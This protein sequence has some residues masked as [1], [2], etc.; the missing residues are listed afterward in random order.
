[1]KSA[2]RGYWICQAVGWGAYL[3]LTV[4]QV[5]ADAGPRIGPQAE[6]V[7]AAAFGVALTHAFRRLV[8]ARGW[9]SLELRAL[10]PRAVLSPFVL[11]VVFVLPLVAIE[12]LLLG[13][14]SGVVVFVAAVVRW[15]LVFAVWEGIYLGVVLFRARRRAERERM[16]L[17][18][19][20][21][22]AQLDALRSQLNPHFLFNALNTVRALIPD[23]PARAQTAVTQLASILRHALGSSRADLVALESELAIADDYLAIESLRLGERLKVERTIDPAALRARVP[24]MLVQTLVENAIK[25][26]IAELR[27]GGTLS[28]CAEVHDGAMLLRVENPRPDGEPR[29]RSGDNGIGLA[30]ARE[31]M[32][33]LFGDEGRVEIDLS[34]PG[35]ASACVR[36]PVRS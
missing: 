2:S 3:A 18:S 27:E 9:I 20:L 25:H 22:A 10:A 15:S 36:V 34:R 11:A 12:R 6:V 4:L 13:M 16:E 1:V 30:N 33:L 35:H 7:F 8:H 26:G 32:R 17:A 24:P 31:R 28:I 19:A 5:R 21:Q 29:A 23:D 14:P